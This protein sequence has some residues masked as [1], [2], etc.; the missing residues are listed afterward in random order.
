M[1]SLLASAAALLAELNQP[2]NITLLTKHLLF[3]PGLWRDS[4]SPAERLRTAIEVIRTFSSAA[5]TRALG[6]ASARSLPLDGWQSAVLQ[7]VHE[8]SQAWR[9]ILLFTGLLLAPQLSPAAA[10]RAGILNE[11]GPIFSNFRAVEHA[12]VTAV[13]KVL[14]EREGEGTTSPTRCSR[15]DDGQQVEE[16]VVAVSLS[17]VFD[18][19]SPS[20]KTRL[21]FQVCG[22]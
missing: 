16:A 9:H 5:K 2:A 19:L 7:G 12:F 6:A 21:D 8:E 11:R 3:G 1:C 10:D 14:A 18:L 20:A 4:D 22:Y 13:G 15:H 17:F